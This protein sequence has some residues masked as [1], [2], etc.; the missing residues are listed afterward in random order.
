M[1]CLVRGATAAGLGL[2]ALTVLVMMVWISSPYHDSGPRGALHVAA[3]LWLLAHGTELVRSDTLYGTAAPVGLVPLLLVALPAW[4]IHRATRD[5][6]VPDGTGLRPTPSPRAAVCGVGLGYLLVGTAAAVYAAGGPI[7]PGAL[8]AACRLPL[9]ALGAAATGVWAANGRPVGPP[10]RRLPARLREPLLRA[11]LP[12]SR[13][14]TAARAATAA[15]A[16]LVGGGAL[17]VATALVWHADATQDSFLHLARIWS[18]RLAV[19]LLGI[20]LVPN[21]AV[22]AAAYGLGPGFALGTGATATPLALSGDPALPAFP[23][24]A[25]VPAQGPGTPLN[26]SS[27]LVPVAAGLAVAVFGAARG[28]TV[29]RR[30]TA[31]DALLAAAFCAVAVAVLAAAAGGPLG[32]GRLAEFGPVWWSAGAAA[33]L[34]TAG[35]GVPGALVVREWRGRGTGLMAVVRARAAAEAPEPQP[36]LPAPVPAG[37]TARAAPAGPTAPETVRKP[38]GRGTAPLRAPK[39]PAQAKALD[40]LD[41]LDAEAE[42]YDYLPPDGWTGRRTATESTPAAFPVTSVNSVDPARP[43]A[44]PPSPWPSAP[45]PARPPDRPEPAA[46]GDRPES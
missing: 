16:V 41:T 22:W 35:I 7:A 36:P 43:W 8:S 14:E 27:V 38:T 24:V 25:V 20:A 29:R 18:G 34:W 1:A 19:L 30:D 44:A 42:P 39:A 5:A 37:A 11:A 26:W 23:L 17:L 40:V 45:S 28:D 32:T 10:P 12:G 15:T 33:L 6:L 46:D 9:V 13:V 4:L 31:A 2:G 21:A 3:S